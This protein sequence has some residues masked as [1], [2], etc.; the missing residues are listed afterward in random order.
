MDT[1]WHADEIVALTR[2]AKH[3]SAGVPGCSVVV[4]ALVGVS[5][6][7]RTGEAVAIVGAAGSG[8]STLALC[9]AGLLQLDAGTVRWSGS[10]DAAGRGAR[11]A[12]SFIDVPS[13]AK[14]TE[15]HDPRGGLLVIDSVDHAVAPDIRRRLHQMIGQATKSGAVLILGRSGDACR[16]LLAPGRL[17]ATRA[18]VGG[19]LMRLDH[20]LRVS[21]RVA[22]R[23]PVDVSSSV[24]RSFGAP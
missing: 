13:I 21:G 1:D 8:K 11:A 23:P 14:A 16:A 17:S 4:Q 2:V 24:D 7:L 9:A 22:E 19:R 15:L 3:F 5:L 20:E 12:C 10:H 18:I 6:V